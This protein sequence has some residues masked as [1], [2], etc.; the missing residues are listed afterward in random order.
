MSD[1]DYVF[2]VSSWPHAI[3]HI[4]ADA[5]FVACEIAT[6]PSLQNKCVVVG[7]ERGIVTALSYQAKTKGIKRGMLIS[8]A[9]KICPS[10]V[11]IESDYEKYSMFSVRMFNILRT[12]SPIVEEYSI[13]EAFVDLNGLRRL[14]KASYLGIAK[15]IQ[16]EIERLLNISVSIGVAPTKVLAKIAS[17]L[18]KP[19]GLVAIQANQIKRYIKDIKV[20]DIWGIGKN[21]AS[22]LNKLGIYTALEF[23]SK[24]ESYLKRFLSKPYIEIYKELKGESV[25]KLNP[26]KKTDF[27]SI[28][29]SKSFNPTNNEQALLSEL[30]KNLEQACAKARMYRLYAKQIVVFLKTSDFQTSSV[31]LKLQSPSN[32]PMLLMDAIKQAFYMIYDKNLRYRQTGV[33]L[34]ELKENV[35]YSLFD[36]PKIE[37]VMRLYK[38]IDKIN[39]KFGQDRIHLAIDAFAISQNKHAQRLNIPF[40]DVEV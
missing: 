1:N 32:T 22:L 14:Y 4:D 2:S 34:S 30:A 11:V 19:H 35:Q 31:K 38:A 36:A 24:S 13:D 21:T 15:L 12:F 20:E 17:K 6:D 23:A 29:K 3:A 8:Q 16:D 28:S 7:K 26:N 40:V 5:F 39:T 33:V 27:K 9:K 10:L 25:L 18:N 37:K